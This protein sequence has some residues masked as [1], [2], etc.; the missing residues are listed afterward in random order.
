MSDNDNTNTVETSLTLQQAWDLWEAS[1]TASKEAMTAEHE[2]L[3]TVARAAGGKTFMQ[4]GQLYQI[5][6]R[7][8]KATGEHVPFICALKR[9]PK[10][11]LAE[12]RAAKYAEQEIEDSA[13]F[14]PT[15]STETVPAVLQD[16]TPPVTEENDGTN[17]SSISG[18]AMFGD[19][20][21]SEDTDD[22]VVLA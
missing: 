8:D 19:S 6:E 17:G 20:D 16:P 7:K 1:Q 11:W 18:A 10:E 9:P 3:R 21:E 22:T 13:G 5:R 15:E 12:A 14:G 2:A 4:D